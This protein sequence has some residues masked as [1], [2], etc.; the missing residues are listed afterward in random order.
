M[1]TSAYV[2]ASFSPQ[3]FAVVVAGLSLAFMAVVGARAPQVD[4]AETQ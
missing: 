2:A 1:P 4:K 3:V